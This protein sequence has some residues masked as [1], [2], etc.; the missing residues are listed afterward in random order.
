M[1]NVDF[2][3]TSPDAAAVSME[4]VVRGLLIT[5]RRRGRTT[6]VCHRISVSL[7]NELREAARRHN[8]RQTEIV[9]QAL[10]IEVAR[11]LSTPSSDDTEQPLAIACPKLWSPARPSEVAP[12]TFR[13]PDSLQDDLREAAR[14]HELRQA[15]ILN[16][17]VEA[18]V[19]RLLA[20]PERSKRAG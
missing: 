8:M 10:E 15:D 17:A 5:R 1:N 13:I 11:L 16:H 14:R 19:A 20:A 4:P 7:H 9:I 2:Q 3:L 6:P 12:A 18:M